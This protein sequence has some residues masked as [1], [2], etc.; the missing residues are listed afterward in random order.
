MADT[1]SV[2]RW[3][4][5]VTAQVSRVLVDVVRDVSYEAGRFLAG[6][7]VVGGPGTEPTEMSGE[8]LR[9]LADELRADLEQTPAG[10]QAAEMRAFLALVPD[11]S[12]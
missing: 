11:T 12:R 9:D 10:V 8:A 1:T 6:S 4:A 2:I 3:R 7:R 5:T